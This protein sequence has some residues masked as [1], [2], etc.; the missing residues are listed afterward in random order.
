MGAY[1]IGKKL[2]GFDMK[3]RRNETAWRTRDWTG[4]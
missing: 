2:N 4:G 3:T 1:R